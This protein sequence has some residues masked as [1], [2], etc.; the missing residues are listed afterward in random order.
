LPRSVFT[1]RYRLF[2]ELLITARVDAGLNQSDLAE[3]LGRPQSF[4]SKYERG[5]R[6]LD[7]VEFLE[8]AAAVGM[9]VEATI[10]RLREPEITEGTG[11]PS[12]A[13]DA[14]PIEGHDTIPLDS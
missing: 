3:R 13:Q 6:R 9:D 2:R 14:Q 4:V 8:V 5:E 11:P 12:F 7:V 1:D 10:R